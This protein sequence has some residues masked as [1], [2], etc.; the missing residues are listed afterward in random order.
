MSRAW[1]LLNRTM[2]LCRDCGI[3]ESDLEDVAMRAID[4]AHRVAR[5]TRVAAVVHTIREELARRIGV[6]RRA[7]PRDVS[8]LKAIGQYAASRQRYLAQ[9][10]RGWRRVFDSHSR[11]FAIENGVCPRCSR[12]GDFDE[13]S[14]RCPCGFAYG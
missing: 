14:G 8:G 1:A 11:R 5:R 6:P 12:A 10:G 2:G 3:P 4:R 9:R 7:L 13:G